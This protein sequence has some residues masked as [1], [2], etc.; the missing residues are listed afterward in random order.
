MGWKVKAMV[1]VKYGAVCANRHLKSVK[2][3]AEDLPVVN[4]C[5]DCG[6]DVFR[7]CP[8]CNTSIPV[9]RYTRSDGS[10]TRWKVKEY[11]YNC[12]EAYPWGPGRARQLVHKAQKHIPGASSESSP[13]PSGRIFSPGVR[14]YLDQTKY[15]DELVSHTSDGDSC[16]RNSLWFP[17]LTMYIHAIEWAAITFLEAEANLDIIEKEREGV[18][19]YLAGGEHSLVDELNEHAD[20]DQKTVS[21]IN[22]INRLERRWVAHHKSGKTKRDDVDAV[23]SRLEILV[24]SLF[25]ALAIEAEGDGNGGG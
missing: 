15:G 8:N 5:D 3:S 10:K 4:Y 20:V 11:C 16:Y 1:D 24:E 12:S 18:N 22:S 21:V 2:D 17:A 23:R 9:R 14:R 25:E 19:Y 7:Q 6:Q 13:T